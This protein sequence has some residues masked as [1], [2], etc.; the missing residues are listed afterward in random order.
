MG[1]RGRK[2]KAEVAIRRVEAKVTVME[3][4]EPP[5]GMP[6]EA[7][8]EWIEIVGA[9]PADHFARPIYPL[10]EAYCTHAAAR[11]D[12]VRRIEDMDEDSTLGEYDRLLGMHDRESRAMASIAVRLGIASATHTK[13]EASGLKSGTGHPDPWDRSS[14]R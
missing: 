5:D 3:R 12:I 9:V 6:D 2:S 10:L 1:T 8:R 11:R 14:I 4:P 7:K 13:A